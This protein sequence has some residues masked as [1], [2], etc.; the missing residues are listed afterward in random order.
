MVKQLPKDQKKKT[1]H[2][3]PESA[4]KKLKTLFKLSDTPEKPTIFTKYTYNSIKSLH[5]FMKATLEKSKYTRITKI[6]LKGYPI[7]NK[8]D[9]CIIKS[10]TGSGKTLAYLVPILNRLMNGQPKVKRED[11]TKVMI[12]C[13]T[14]ELCIQ[15]HNTLLQIG[16]ACVH[17]VSGLLVGGESIK[18]EKDKLRKGLNVII[19][20]PGRVKYHLEHT[21]TFSLDNLSSLVLEECD[22]TLD[23]GFTR[24]INY[25]IEK[26]NDRL[27]KVQKVL[28]S[29]CITEKVED[30]LHQLSIPVDSDV[31]MIG[32][33]KD[34]IQKL[35]LPETLSHFYIT[36]D[37][38]VKII[39]FLMIVKILEK[40]KSVIFVATADEANYFE[41]LLKFARTEFFRTYNDTTDEFYTSFIGKIHGYVE[42]KDRS[43]V[44]NKFVKATSGC[45]I[46]TDVGSR[47]LNFENISV[48]VLFDVS[49][50][51]KDY[52]NRVGRT[53]RIENIGSALS[54]LTPSE[55]NYA[56]KL[57]QNCNAEELKR[58]NIEDI[59]KGLLNEKGNGHFDTLNNM[60]KQFVANDDNSYLA[61]RAFNSFCRAYAM[62]KDKDCFQLKNMNLHSISKSFGLDSSAS[63]KRGVASKTSD[64]KDS[65]NFLENRVKDS[66]RRVNQMKSAIKKMQQKNY[67]VN[68]FM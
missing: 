57:K 9:D 40:V 16:K 43:E 25:I 19:A 62:L 41:A 17:I 65:K 60:I 27:F 1:Y 13:P 54:F 8:G 37:E 48:I 61:R 47:G 14:R 18:K 20:T 7:L 29:A 31:K 26:L 2:L 45:L 23:M 32:F 4:H 38:R 44:F 6:Q 33:D 3:D 34:N 30:L 53:A 21:S 50:S 66:D 49:Q 15:I 68:E 64:M 36:L 55:T 24:E 67:E 11:G 22:R 28:V 56:E 58:Y 63:R 35:D 5:P 59:F 42:Q 39:Y 10:Q 52:V 12:I 46:T 51:Y